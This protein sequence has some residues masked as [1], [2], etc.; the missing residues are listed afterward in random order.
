MELTERAGAVVLA[1]CSEWLRAF[2]TPRPNR[3]DQRVDDRRQLLHGPSEDA[4]F[5]LLELQEAPPDPD[6]EFASK[7]QER[8]TGPVS[9]E[10]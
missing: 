2:G 10:D 9:R 5:P 4:G 7:V 3:L 8:R 1:S 6:E